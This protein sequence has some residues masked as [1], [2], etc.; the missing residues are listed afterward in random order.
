[1]ERYI[2]DAIREKLKN[3]YL[4]SDYHEQLSFIFEQLKDYDF[5]QNIPNIDV[6]GD[7]EKGILFINL[8][9]RDY[10]EEKSKEQS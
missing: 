1:M 10:S 5:S 2:E 8:W 6:R 7:K 3:Y 4:A 9:Y